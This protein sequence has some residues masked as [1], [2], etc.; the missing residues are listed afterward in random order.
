MATISDQLAADIQKAFNK[1]Y[2][3]LTNQDQI[4][5][6]VGDVK[7]TKQDGSTATV[8]S[9]N[10]VIGALDTAAQR[11][12]Q[13]SFSSLQIFNAGIDASIGN[14]N[15]SGDGQ[16]I[17]LG[18]NSDIGLVKKQGD[19]GKV[20]VGKSNG[21][22]V[23]A[24]TTNTVSATGE[25]NEIM[26]VDGGGNLKLPGG[27]VAAGQGYFNSIELINATP[28]IDFHYGNNS[29]ADFTHRILAEDG[30][31]S[32]APGFR[33]KG[34]TGLYGI[35]T[36]YGEAYGQGF[37]SRLNN[38]P[39]NVATG[40]ILA[41][42]RVTVRF[43]SRGADGNVDGGQGAMWFEEQAGT[44]HRLVLM[45]GGFGA[46][47]QYWQFLADGNIWSSANGGV[48][49]TGTSDARFKHDIN[50]TDGSESVKRL[51]ALQLVTFIYN[52]DDQNRVRRGIVAQQA[53]GV[54]PQYVKHIK[55]SVK[56]S[57]GQDV[58]IDKMQLDNNVIMMDTLAAT[59]VLIERVERLEAEIKLLKGE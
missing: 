40:T 50:P 30:A 3:D 35:C 28:Y 56:G 10:K 32:V 21:F 14:I 24:S 12:E 42:P 44:N 23:H 31:L 9:W 51:K 47:V 18:K 20:V 39:Q 25:S 17:Y 43:A 52:D 45:V 49:F 27:V 54:D 38:D 36:Q 33:V 1:Y 4:F 59:K 5:F 34:P 57:D 46:N 29:A 55:T 48:Q 13:N 19:G 8:R 37:I 22:R 58:E 15:C 26:S 11:N 7:I 6:G 16:M 41:S 53:R 2:T